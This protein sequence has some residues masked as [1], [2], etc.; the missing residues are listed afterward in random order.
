VEIEYAV[1]A[2]H[3]HRQAL[4][5]VC[6]LTGDRGAFKSCDLLEIGE[7]RYFHAVAPAFPAQSPRA[8]RWRFPVVLHEANIV[9]LGIYSDR[10][11]RAQIEILQVERGGLENNLKLIIV[12]EPVWVF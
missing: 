7:L 9:Q 8:Q 1:H 10:I 5:P 11:K 12:L 4:K 6:Q 3:V 2:L